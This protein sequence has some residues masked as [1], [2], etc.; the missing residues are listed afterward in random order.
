LVF[1]VG[2]LIFLLGSLHVPTIVTL[3]LILAV[4]LVCLPAAKWVARLV[5]GKSC[6]FTIAG[7]FFVGIFVTPAVLHVFNL[8]L[9]GMG[10]RPVPIVPA[11]AAVIIGYAFGEALGR[12]ACISFGCCYGVSLSAAHP[13]LQKVLGRGISSSQVR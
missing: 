13:I 1:G 11:L 5:E 10:L 4:L 3:T 7:A 12:L 8:M 6:T 9:P 2:L